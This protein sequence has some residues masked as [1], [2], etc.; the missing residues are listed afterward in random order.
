VVP[1]EH[2]ARLV[3]G[4]LHRTRSGTPA[5]T[6]FRTA[7]RRKSWRRIPGTPA[8]RQAVAQALRKSRWRRPRRRAPERYGS[9]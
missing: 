2:A 3:P 9:S 8:S 6:R 7:V 5:L 4:D 1:V